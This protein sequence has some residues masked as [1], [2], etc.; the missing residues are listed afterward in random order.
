MWMC[1]S[2]VIG[3]YVSGAQFYIK[4]LWIFAE[5]PTE[6]EYIFYLWAIKQVVSNLFF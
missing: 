2:W 5:C 1:C 6:P 3:T 4:F